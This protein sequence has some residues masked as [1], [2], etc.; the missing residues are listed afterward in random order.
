MENQVL[1]VTTDFVVIHVSQIG[2]DLFLLVKTVTAQMS[3][4]MPV[5]V[6]SEPR[7][8]RWAYR[9]STCCVLT[10]VAFPILVSVASK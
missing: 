4:I 2:R 7:R 3:F 1:L 5:V 6:F 9:L 10:R 8:Q